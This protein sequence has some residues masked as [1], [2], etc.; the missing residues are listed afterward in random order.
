MLKTSR[1]L[2]RIVRTFHSDSNYRIASEYGLREFTWILFYR[3]L[4]VLR[5]LKIRLVA[6]TEGTVFCGRSVCIEH[7]Y[8]I[9]AGKSLVIEDNVYINALSLEGIKFGRKVFVGRGAVIVCTGVVAQKG[10]GLKIGDSS[11][12]GAYSY[13]GCQGGV[14]IGNDVIIGPGLKMFS[15]NHNFQ[16]PNELIRKQGVHRK[17]IRVGDNCWMG[18]NVTI[19]D[20]VEIGDGC[21][22]A[23]GSLINKSIPANSVV[24]GIPARVIKSRA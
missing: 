17:G 4:Q 9:S 1:I 3:G 10:V 23:A 12:I 16:N 11:G 20:G 15:E 2:E 6:T 5:G 18:C 14:S 21:V 24:A 19:L 13:I 22:I 7:G 8:N